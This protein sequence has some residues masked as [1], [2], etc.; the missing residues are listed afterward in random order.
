MKQS[1][2]SLQFI[3]T[4]RRES[5]FRDG[6]NSCSTSIPSARIPSSVS[7]NI[8][9]LITKSAIA[10][11]YEFW[12]STFFDKINSLFNSSSESSSEYVNRALFKFEGVKIGLG[13]SNKI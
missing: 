9:S 2:S 5:F 10:S 6:R 4:S 12:P 1:S 7:N 3:F 8:P 13:G 11:T